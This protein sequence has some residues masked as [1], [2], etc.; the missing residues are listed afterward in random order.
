M[1]LKKD[2][3]VFLFIIFIGLTLRLWK[4]DIPLLE[5]Y[6]SRQIQTAN[7]TKNL[8]EDNFNFLYPRVDYFGPSTPYYLIEFPG[9]NLA[10]SLISA[11]FGGFEDIHGRIVSILSYILASIFLYLLVKRAL[12]NNVALYSIT[13]FSLSPLNILTS[14]A[15]QPDEMMLF[16][17]IACIYFL[18]IWFFGKKH[19]FLLISALFFSWALLLKV[20]IAVFLS[21]LILYVFLRSSKK[22]LNN[23]FLIAIFA[24]SFI[25]ALLWYFRSYSFSVA[26]GGLFASDYRLVNWFDP[27]L[28][29][30]YSYWA[31]IFGFELNLVFLP[32]GLLL[33]VV[34][35]LL[36]TRKGI[37]FFY[38]WLTGIIVYFLVFNRHVM[39]HE[40]Y[41]LP[42]VPV[43]SVFIALG[44]EKLIS[45]IW[46]GSFFMEI[47]KRRIIFELMFLIIFIVFMLPTVLSRAYRP[48]DRFKNVVETGTRIK[49]L[50]EQSDLVIGSMD[51]GPSLVYYSERTGWGF[52]VDRDKVRKHF[53]LIKLDQNVLDS[54]SYL[55]VLRGQGAKVFA[56]SY[57]E[58]FL[59]N[60]KF[61]TYMYNTYPV[62]Y[63]T[64]NSIIFDLQQMRK[65]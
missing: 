57:K 54:I 16:S 17:S 61:S 45:S 39:T 30:T 12:G 62:I 49:E 14:R 5:F 43:G 1:K 31:N 2:I 23:Y 25:P 51:G 20:T 7:I 4:L 15:F 3:L 13:F 18:H 35:I 53:A 36:K 55:E 21:P 10:V 64:E 65:R 60:P 56:S 33:F 59:A 42:F 63:E 8:I 34:G 47:L 22:G 9:Y 38:L 44:A 52:E 6:P 50:T 40:Y 26:N 19:K 48:I 24:V 29:L 58:Q 28:L 46:G 11:L 37:E 32:V 41:H 27:S